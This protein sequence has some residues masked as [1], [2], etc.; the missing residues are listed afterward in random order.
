MGDLVV[1]DDLERI[2]RGIVA[3]SAQVQ[4]HGGVT[5]RPR[6]SSTSGTTA[7]R[8]AR[9]WAVSWLDCQ[10]VMCGQ[11]AV[12]AAEIGQQARQHVEMPRL[13]VGDLDPVVA[14]ALAYRLR[15]GRRCPR[16]GRWRSARYGRA[17]EA[18]P[19]RPAA[20][21]PFRRP[22]CRGRAAVP[23]PLGG[24]GGPVGPPA[25]LSDGASPPFLGESAGE[26]DLF[27]R[28]RRGEDGDGGG[29]ESHRRP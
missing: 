15:T 7:S 23:A 21:P 16:R 24:R 3:E 2:R 18:A 11:G 12:P 26:G 29:A 13:V 28:V 1:V 9:S 4:D 20:L 14:E 22:A 19:L 27:S 6:A 17:R 5:S 10:S 25:D 8:A